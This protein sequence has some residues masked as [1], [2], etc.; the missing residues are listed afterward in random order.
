[1]VVINKQL[2]WQ[3]NGVAPMEEIVNWCNEFLTYQV[4]SNGYETFY[5]DNEAAYTAF[6]LRWIK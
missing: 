4:W 6:L 3:Y 2:T 5:F 1:M